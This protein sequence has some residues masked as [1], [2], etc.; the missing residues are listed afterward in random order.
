MQTNALF[1]PQD[2]AM[3]CFVSICFLQRKSRLRKQPRCLCLCPYVATRR[4]E[5]TDRLFVPLQDTSL[6]H[7]LIS[8]YKQFQLARFRASFALQATSLLF[9]DVTRLRFVIGYEY[10]G[11]HCRSHRSPSA[12]SRTGNRCNRKEIT[13]CVPHSLRLLHINTR[14]VTLHLR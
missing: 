4:F 13:I 9:C 12:T 10:F 14:Y 7:I 11:E 3:T 2:T 1:C 6:C 5:Q 8:S